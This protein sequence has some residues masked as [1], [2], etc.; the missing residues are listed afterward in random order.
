MLQTIKH[1][2]GIVV[3]HHWQ[4]TIW[5]SYPV[6]GFR[7]NDNI[8]AADSHIQILSFFKEYNIHLHIEKNIAGASSIRK[9]LQ[10]DQKLQKPQIFK[11]Y[12]FALFRIYNSIFS[13][14]FHNMEK[15]YLMEYGQP[16]L[17]WYLNHS[18]KN[19]INYFK[20]WWPKKNPHYSYLWIID[21]RVLRKSLCILLHRKWD[22]HIGNS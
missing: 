14:V 21:S 15:S 12:I 4:S 20:K 16:S 10:I 5:D 7:E 2:S 6:L 22:L 19:S 18:P 9:V 8:P 13:L 1:G 3:I 11:C 17:V